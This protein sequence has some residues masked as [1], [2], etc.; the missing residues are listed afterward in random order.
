M[1][2]TLIKLDL[3]CNVIRNSPFILDRD[4]TMSLNT[5]SSFVNMYGDMNYMFAA[6]C[7]IY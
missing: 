3:N 1:Q 5:V 4:E 2:F 6:N 7:V